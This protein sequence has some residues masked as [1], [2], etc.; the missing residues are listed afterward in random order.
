MKMNHHA[1]H[2]L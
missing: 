2:I 1:W